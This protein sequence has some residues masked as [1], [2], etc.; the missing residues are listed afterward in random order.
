M[1][2]PEV[3]EDLADLP[4][5]SHCVSFHADEEEAAR[6]AASFLAGS[7]P[8]Q[9]THYWVADVAAAERCARE[10]LRRTDPEHVGCVAILSREQV[11]FV[12]GRLRPIPEVT[13]FVEAHPEGVTAGGETLSHYWSPGDVPEH[14]EYEAWFDEQPRENSR[15]LCPYDLRRIPPHLAPTILRDLGSH[16][17]HVAL[18]RSAEPIEE[19]LELFVFGLPSELPVRLLPTFEAAAAAGLVTAAS[20]T[21]E[22]R[23]TVAGEHRVQEWSDRIQAQIAAREPPL[24]GAP[25]HWGGVAPGAGEHP[26]A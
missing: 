16:H 7:P 11:E 23:L 13:E 14:L 18:S 9:P 10:L 3:I 22:L 24:E 19:L 4:L 25:D 1:T 5:G 8:Q 17:S 26:S 12:G 20:P 21:A 15:F 6:Q 2:A